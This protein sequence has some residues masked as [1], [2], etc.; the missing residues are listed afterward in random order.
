MN[1][2]DIYR[3]KRRKP[4]AARVGVMGVGHHTYWGQFDGLYTELEAKLATLIS[5]EEIS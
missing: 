4:L 1:K 3:V 2:H 5:K